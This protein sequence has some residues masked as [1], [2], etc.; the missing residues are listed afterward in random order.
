M[1]HFN[2]W[3]QSGGM[4]RAADYEARET[5]TSKIESA[6]ELQAPVPIGALVSQLFLLVESGGYG[7]L[8]YSAVRQAIYG[9]PNPPPP[10]PTCC[11]LC[12]RSVFC[13]PCGNILARRG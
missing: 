2:E 4:Q 13:G 11:G 10:P 7:Q 12:G 1:D 8:D 9:A 5:A 6:R 3:A